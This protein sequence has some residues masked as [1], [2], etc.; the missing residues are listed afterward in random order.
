MFQVILEPFV[1]HVVVINNHLWNVR[2]MTV[3]ASTCPCRRLLKCIHE[4]ISLDT[5]RLGPSNGSVNS[6]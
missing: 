1:Q 6:I 5:C 2:A 4:Y 3:S